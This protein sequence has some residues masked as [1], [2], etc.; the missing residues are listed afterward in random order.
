MP[1]KTSKERKRIVVNKSRHLLQGS[2]FEN[3]LVINQKRNTSMKKSWGAGRRYG[4]KVPR[5]YEQ[6]LAT[7]IKAKLLLFQLFFDG[8]GGGRHTEPAEIGTTKRM[9]YLVTHG[10]HGINNFI[11]RNQVFV[12]R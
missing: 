3:K 6:G 9:V 1:R 11:E 5:F 12:I 8:F 4:E 7:F 10:F 2:K